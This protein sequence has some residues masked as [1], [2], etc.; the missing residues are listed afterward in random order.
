MAFIDP[1]QRQ[2]EERAKRNA[3]IYRNALWPNARVPYVISSDFTGE[4][5]YPPRKVFIKG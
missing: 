5:Q 1:P 2:G 3:I 4:Q